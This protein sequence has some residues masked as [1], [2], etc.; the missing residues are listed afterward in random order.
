MLENI[1]SVTP[2]QIN[3]YQENGFLQIHNFFSAAEAA[4]IKAAMLRG[5]EQQ[6]E[7]PAA[8]DG[9]EIDENYARVFRQ[10]VNLWKED[11]ELAQVTLNR[12]IAETARKLSGFDGLRLWHDQALIKP[13]GDDSRETNWHQDTPYWPMNEPGGLSIWIALD[14]VTKE[15]GCMWFAPKSRDMGY[16]DPVDL[17]ADDPT[18]MLER[19]EL[20]GKVGE[21][22]C[23]EMKAGGV[24][25]H[26]GLTLHYAGSNLS[27]RPRNAFVVLYM[28]ANATFNADLKW[29]DQKHPC[30]VGK[31]LANGAPL[32]DP[33]FPLL[34]GVE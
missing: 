22:V 13:G 9:G 26:D 31:G 30:T 16:L 21:P 27:D 18:G 14:D 20:K 7:A 8:M 15:S 24:T 28:P 29:G 33:D 34:A 11:E 3:F 23:C 19:T 10:H 1:P 2:E 4:R 17:T 5:I 6:D 25:F 12:D 32:N